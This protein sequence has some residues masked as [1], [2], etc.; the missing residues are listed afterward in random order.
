MRTVLSVPDISCE[1][2]VAAITAAVDEVPG[3][4]AVQ[5]ELEGKRVLVDGEFSAER[6]IAAI[7]DS[8]YEVAGR[9]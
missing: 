3:V 5:V 1:H 4:T 6:V 2:C 8:G 9:G 7:T